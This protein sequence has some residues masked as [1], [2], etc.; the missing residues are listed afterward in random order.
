MTAL[1]GTAVELVPLADAVM[2]LKRVPEDRMQ[3][4]ES[5]F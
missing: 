1:H 5:V 4:A 2:V 3:E